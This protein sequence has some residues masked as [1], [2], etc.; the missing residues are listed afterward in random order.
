[1]LNAYKLSCVHCNV[2]Y[3]V[4]NICIC[5]L[6]VHSGSYNLNYLQSANIKFTKN[7]I[8]ML[9]LTIVNNTIVHLQFL[10]VYNNYYDRVFLCGTFWLFTKNELNSSFGSIHQC[11]TIFIG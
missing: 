7:K 4:G 3:N 10:S 8:E 1:M 11:Y 9:W 2:L 5:S 6:C